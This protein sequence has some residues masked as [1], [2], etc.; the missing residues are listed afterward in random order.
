MIIRGRI[1]GP[2]PNACYVLWC[3]GVGV[4]CQGNGTYNEDY[5]KKKWLKWLG[6]LS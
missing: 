1:W 3:T 6:Y 4:N 5:N 2:T